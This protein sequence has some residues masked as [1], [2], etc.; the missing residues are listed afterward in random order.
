MHPDDHPLFLLKQKLPNP[1][2]SREI[3]ASEIIMRTS[4]SYKI[5]MQQW[6]YL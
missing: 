1:Y 3:N 2:V 6:Y 4:A 5:M